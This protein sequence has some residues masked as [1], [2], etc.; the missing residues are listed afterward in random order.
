MTL[1]LL[2]MGKVIEAWLQQL[3]NKLAEFEYDAGVCCGFRDIQSATGYRL[4][5]PRVA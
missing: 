1:T 3:Q 5:D 2:P 4:P